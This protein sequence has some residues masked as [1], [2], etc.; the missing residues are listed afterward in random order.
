M[1]IFDIR[2]DL[3]HNSVIFEP[4][5]IET[6]R[7][8]GIRDY[9]NNWLDDFYKVAT[10]VT[11]LD[12]GSGDYLQEI[13]SHLSIRDSLGKVNA[14]LRDTELATGEVKE[15]YT[16]YSFLWEDDIEEAFQEFLNDKEK[17]DNKDDIESLDED[18]E[19]EVKNP[20]LKNCVEK[21]PSLI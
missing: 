2:I 13:K 16:K 10:L 20:I 15:R 7:G 4:E 11:R 17:Y 3:Q 14:C 6:S 18:R 9:V 1:P 5:I 21:M 19:H 12:V 8:N